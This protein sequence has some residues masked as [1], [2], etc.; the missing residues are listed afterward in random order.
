MT[1][2][3]ITAR[4]AMLSRAS[5]MTADMLRDSEEF[6]LDEV[7]I[8]GTAGS[9][10][11]RLAVLRPAGLAGPTPCVYHLHGGGMILGDRY[12]GLD[13]VAGWVRD[14]GVTVASVEYRLA[15]E[16]PYPAAAEDCLTGLAWIAANADDLGIDPKRLVVAGASAGGGLAAG[17]ALAIRD[18]GGAPLAALM[19]MSP[20]LDDRGWFPSSSAFAGQA[21]W[22][23]TSNQTGW[24]AFL[25]AAARSDD[26]PGYAAPGRAR[27]LAGLPPTFIDASSADIFRDEDLDFAARLGHA[28]VPTEVHLWAG[29]FHG[30]DLTVPEA[31]VSGA[32]RAAR[33][34][35]LRRLLAAG[36]RS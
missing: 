7:E 26:V 17:M 29:T 24:D 33:L 10:G 21:P 34:S 18:H 6:R 15:P 35:F 9:A 3:D 12:L 16:H 19:L 36:G 5:A 20:M 25:G 32:C 4:R 30:F 22:D 13:R 27:T 1:P 31:P 2:S 14:A 11:V 28:Q 8:P 23:G